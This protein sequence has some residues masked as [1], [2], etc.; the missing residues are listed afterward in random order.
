M[1]GKD[2]CTVDMG[3]HRFLSETEAHD[4]GFELFGTYGINSCSGVLIVGDNGY[5]VAHLDPIEETEDG[6]PDPATAQAFHDNVV[7]QVEADYNSN[8]E[9]LGNAV[10]YILT[11]QGDKGEQDELVKSAQ[12]LGIPVSKN[13]YQVVDED[14]LNDDWFENERG[15]IYLNRSDTDE[16]FV[17]VNGDDPA[18]AQ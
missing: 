11:P 13:T 3:E 15:T 7:G 5:A 9:N 10:M 16:K 2:S 8:K 4:E 12:R 6:S 18:P 14:G 17:V 1:L